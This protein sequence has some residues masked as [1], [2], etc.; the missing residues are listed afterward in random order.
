VTR[1]TFLSSIAAAQS[2]PP[3]NV[4]LLMADSWRG[5]ALPFAGDS[6]LSLPNLSRL[7][8]E[9][10]WCSR[11][12]TSYPV[13]CPSRAAV[14]TGKFP[15]AAGVTRNHSRLPLGEET[16]SAVLR[17]AGYRTGYIGKWHLDGA[18]SPGFVP[19]ERRRGFGYWAAYN[20]AH[21]H[22]E[23]VYF[24]DS[25]EPV[26]VD[27]FEPDHLTRLAVDFLKQDRSK[28]FF[29]YLSWV[30]PHAPYTPPRKHRRNDAGA[31]RLRPNVP[32]DP[33][34][35]VRADLAGYYGLC[36][37]VDENVGRLLEEIDG[38]GR[39]RDTIVVFTSDHG[40]MLGSHGIDG[41][42]VPYEEA[43]RVPLL[44]RYPRRVAAGTGIDAL[45][46]NVDLAPSLLSLC[47][48]EAPAGIQGF[49]LAGLLT[50][51]GGRRPE[52]AYAE[53]AIGQPGEWRMIV[54]GLDKLVVD[55]SRKPTHLFNLGLDPY[56]RENLVEE[57]SKRL[58]RD[59]LGEQLRRWAFR[60]GD[61]LGP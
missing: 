13:C 43:C 3:P 53:G 52:S 38:G 27:G 16:L 18:E 9:G 34:D 45:V 47:G 8:R 5:Q 58:I 37:A 40:H 31:L 56:E 36:S 20:V 59:E 57:E 10:A 41:I 28:P 51:A 6:N 21:R 4:L 17:R 55:R 33:A 46:S 30:P 23:S 7:A 42:D 25:P 29:L 44:I 1:R 15:H 26:P 32:G 22:Y 39:A 12:Y 60:T 19:P 14:L 11:T 50:G 61:R 35:Q 54:R 2:P 48:V 24:R 49:D